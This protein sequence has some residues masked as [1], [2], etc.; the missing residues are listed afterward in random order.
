MT[1]QTA[2]LTQ[3]KTSKKK[4]S[5]VA[6]QSDYQYMHSYTYTLED[7]SKKV[8]EPIAVLKVDENHP[9]PATQNPNLVQI[10][11]IGEA[12]VELLT[13]ITIKLTNLLDIGS[14]GPT[15]NT[16][17]A[18]PVSLKE[19]IG[20]IKQ[21]LEIL[22][23]ITEF[24]DIVTSQVEK[25]VHEKEAQLA[26]FI[27]NQLQKDFGSALGSK[28][29]KELGKAAQKEINNLTDAIQA[30]LKDVFGFLVHAV[31]QEVLRAAGL[32]GDATSLRQ[33]ADQFQT[34]V[35]PNVSSTFDNDD[36]F[37][38]FQVSGPNPLVIERII[39]SLPPKFPVDDD[40]YRKV[41]GD[42]DSLALA[43]AENRLYF[44]DYKALDVLEP[45]T[46]PQQKYIAASMGLF[47]VKKGDTSGAL[48]AVAIQVDQVPSANNPV[49]YPFHGDTWTL[50]KVHFQAANSNYHE[51][52]SHLG[53]THLLIEP[54][55]VSTQRKLN[56]SH[57]VYNLLLPHFQGTLFINNAAILTLINPGGGVD[58]TLGGTIETGWDVTTSSLTELNFNERM[59]PNQLAGR[60]M[61]NKDL[62]VSYP[63]R[64]DAMDVWNAIKSWAEDYVDIY[65]VDDKQVADDEA[66]QAWLIDLTSEDGGRINGLGEKDS[67]G[68]LGIYTKSY[69]VD[70]L[71]MVIFTSSA[72]HAAVNFPQLSV[73]SYTPSMPLAAYA[74]APTSTEGTESQ[75][76]LAT[77]PPLEQ[78]LQQL[79][80]THGLG[81]VYFTRLG[82]Y[83]R[84][85]RGNYFSNTKVQ[86]A[87]ETFRDRLDA[88]ENQIGERNLNR[89]MY[90]SLLPS[91]IPQS[92]NI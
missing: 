16:S 63:Y 55:A 75:D 17:A 64:D 81:G 65:Y 24:A 61:A 6:G 7:G 77:L 33:Y 22:N 54:F 80:I 87:L 43:I 40:S 79:L 12:L 68:T 42:D 88:V 66:L 69:L 41:M 56:N 86:A 20:L 9:F 8:L 46:F 51:L 35:V 18:G 74:P 38:A 10:I 27:E 85:Q 59:L 62:P 21:K 73:M 26:K 25:D 28:L 58:R 72:Q 47:A 60:F 50:G 1:E 82:D 30:L 37:A 14:V 92:I 2:E 90:Q 15:S 19:V 11:Q 53:L 5:P 36:A 4:S 29:A 67:D 13:N 34:I 31:I 44:T 49:L 3:D 32:H 57:P 78:A 71:T 48:H 89:P 83:N 91:R 76:L 70:V 84:H 52:I 39:D 45:G 23:N